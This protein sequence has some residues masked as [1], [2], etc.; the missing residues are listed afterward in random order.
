MGGDGGV[1]T[2]RPPVVGG[3]FGDGGMYGGGLYG[4]GGGVSRTRASKVAVL[5][6]VVDG[7]RAPFVDRFTERI[8]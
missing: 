4:G 7:W 6:G 3:A 5:V 8:F 2:V 1:L